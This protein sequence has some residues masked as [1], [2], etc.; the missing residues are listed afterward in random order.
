MKFL[1]DPQLP[2]RLARRFATAGHDA[3]HT[4]DLPAGN[5]TTDTEIC[6]VADRDGRAVVTKD[7]DV[8]SSFLLAGRPRRLVLVSIGNSTNEALEQR[9]FAELDGIALAL[10]D[11][12]FVELTSAGLVVHEG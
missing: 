12:G 7:A 9:L 6:A 3:I 5:R 4:G 8:V 1:I 10:S 11:S 2:R